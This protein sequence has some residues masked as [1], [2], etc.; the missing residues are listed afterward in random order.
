MT[1]PISYRDIDITGGFWRETQRRNRDVTVPAVLERFR[2]T[3][4]F[5]AFRCETRWPEGKKPHYFWDSDVAKWIESAAYLLQR[6]SDPLL[7]QA[8]EETVALIEKNQWADGY[9]NIYFTVVEPEGRWKNRDCHELYCAG[10]LIEAAVAYYEATGRRRL[11]DC[12]LRY[13][14]HIERV[15]VLEGNAAFRTPGHE[16]IELAL[17]RLYRCTED[18]R[19]LRL[20]QWFVEQRGRDG[21]DVAARPDWMRASYNQSHLPAREQ[22]TAEG[23]A[24]RAMYLYCAMADL[25]AECGD[26]GLADACRALFGN[27]TQ[28]RMYVT[29]GVGS[30]RHGEAF[31]VDYDLPGETAYSE[32][33]AAIGLALF[34][35]RM[36]A[37]EPDGRYADTAERAIYNGLLSGVSQ[38]GAAFFYENPLEIHPALRRKDASVRDNE[39]LP[40]TRRQQVF[41]C[42]CCPPNITRFIASFGDFLFSKDNDTLYVHHYACARTEQV[43][44]ATEYPREG[45]ISLKLRGMAGR[46]VAL[47]IPGWC[48]EFT[49]SMP[50]ELDRGYFYVTIPSDEFALELNLEMPPRLVFAHPRVYENIGRAAVTRGP[51]VYCM[52][53]VDN[54]ENLR[55]LS[56]A[57]GAAFTGGF[58]MLECGGYRLE[59]PAALY[60]FD[61]PKRAPQKLR[62][63]PYFRFANRGESEMAVWVRA[64]Q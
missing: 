8:V 12:M 42:S 46:R 45:N 41:G 17:V 59:E 39:R 52:E 55:A 40:I 60:S 18:E 21:A 43:E 29:G 33:C 47:R 49:C 4:R 10:H 3:G 64:E 28:R 62:F 22:A 2:E 20:S 58:N 32:T 7:E 1:Q 44:M 26:T 16:E 25:A 57:P 48:G 35:R 31:T 56:I 24:V 9:F 53:S 15:F 19:W 50:G 37:L 13:A 38:D 11:L 51:V 14:A 63:I 5:D 27:I 23:H 30:S 6:E 61:M 36:S 34:C 54:G